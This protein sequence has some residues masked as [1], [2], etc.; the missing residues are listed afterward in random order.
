M[1]RGY[2][3]IAESVPVARRALMAVAEA[4]GVG[5]DQLEAVSLSVSEALTNVVVHAYPGR[6]GWIQVSAWTAGRELVILIA[7]EGHGLHAHSDSPGLGVGLALIAKLTDEFEILQP[8]SGGTQV[9]MRFRLSSR[10]SPVE[11]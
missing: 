5:D 8:P 1:S 3:A 11:R 2:A 6:S 10:G 9:K 7:D 4:A